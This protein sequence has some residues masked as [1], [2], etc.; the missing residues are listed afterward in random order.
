M[1]FRLALRFYL[2]LEIQSGLYSVTEGDFLFLG[3]SGAAQMWSVV[4]L[5][6]FAVGS[7]GFDVP[8]VDR[9]SIGTVVSEFACSDLD[10]KT[11]RLADWQDQPILVLAFVRADCPLAE[12]YG[13]R[14]ARLARDHH[15]KGVRFVGVACDGLETSDDLRRFAS[16]H[17]FDFPVILDRQA[18]L[19]DQVG[20]RRTPEVVVLDQQ[21]R[22]RYRG[23]IDDQYAIGSRKP[24]PMRQDLSEAL[25][26]LIAGRHVTQP[27]VDAVGCPINRPTDSILPGATT[28]SRDI[29]PIFQ[30][31]CVECH[32]PGQVGPFALQTYRQAASWAGSI[33][34]AVDDGRMPPWHANPAHGR[35][36][37]DSRL[38]DREKR[39]I[40]EWVEAGVP[41][42][43]PAD[44]PPSAK[45][46]EGWR[47]S[48]PDQVVTMPQSYNVPAEGVIDYQYFEVDPGFTED[49][50]I[51]ASEIQPGNRKVV[52]HCNVFLKDPT[53]RGEIDETGELGS[54]CLD[55]MTPGSP[56]M[57]LP[58][59]SAK[60]I[61]AGWHLLFV[62]HYSP[63][64][65]PQS[66]RTSIGLVFADPAKVQREVA[67]NL[68]F[69]PDLRIPPGVADHR[70][71]RSRRFDDDVLLLALFPHMHLRG[72]SFRYDAIFPDG[73]EEILLDVPRYDFRWQNRYELAEPKRLPAGTILRC[74]AHFDNS[75]NNPDDPYPTAEV[76]TGKQSWEEMFNGYHH[77]VLADE[78]LMRPVPLLA[79]ARKM[80]GVLFRFGAILG[81]IPAWLLW[82]KIR[83]VSNQTTQ[84]APV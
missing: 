17:S 79:K 78:D 53:S 80:V 36:A 3:A 84:K 46:S 74:G 9:P 82:K 37:N 52:H 19:A 83:R 73:R 57:V 56:P 68:V 72:K 10:G 35:F 65:T 76:R 6:L 58:L 64:G 66:D 38:T 7:A 54:Y 60:R 16:A 29:A 24:E 31:R 14:L 1:P 50:W 55:A 42:G 44:L 43:N 47:I 12:L 39:R 75:S 59:G 48:K 67:T 45:F 40:A 8:G 61:P 32:R 34:S 25:A 69:D 13:D 5:S 28:Y 81:L 33:A 63:I 21:R 22:I 71:E 70:V 15:A 27:E 18:K 49:K 62:V 77:I 23:R 4:L 30:R 11:R 20:A 51:A 2:G 26:E 41:E